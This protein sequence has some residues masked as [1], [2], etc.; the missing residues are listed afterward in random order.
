[1]KL[2]VIRHGQSETNLKKVYTG[3]FDAALTESGESD[4]LFAREKL[5]GIKFDKVFSSDLS[6]AIKTAEIALP[7]HNPLT[8]SLLREIDVGTLANKFIASLTENTKATIRAKGFSEFGGEGHEEF[9]ERIHNF[10]E[11]VKNCEAENVAAFSHNGFILHMLDIVLGINVPK[12]N[13]VCGNCAIYIFEY[14]GDTW[15]LHSIINK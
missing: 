3:W 14:F 15:K 1:M 12:R 11:L 2:Y 8:T 4:A 6:R 13:I 10:L 9:H 7:Y 5:S